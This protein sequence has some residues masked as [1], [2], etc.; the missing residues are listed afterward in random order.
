MD[1]S[2]DSVPAT[3]DRLVYSVAEAGSTARYLSRLRLRTRCPRRAPSHS[4]GS[5]ASHPQGCPQRSHWP[6][7]YEPDRLQRVLSQLV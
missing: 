2:I 1:I 3:E 6:R 5:P 7:A 4:P